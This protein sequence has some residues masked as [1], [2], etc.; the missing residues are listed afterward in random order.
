MAIPHQELL[1]HQAFLERLARDLARD[2]ERAADL[3]QET[4]VRALE[5]GPRSAGALRAWFARVARHLALRG[6][7]RDANRRA[8][9]RAAARPEAEVEPRELEARLELERRVL[10]ALQALREPY[11]SALF[12][13]Y[14]EGLAPAEIARR[15]GAP[16]GTVKTRLKRGLELL[17]ADLA[18]DGDAL[19]GLLAAAPLLAPPPAA[20]A[21]A[22]LGGWLVGTKLVCGAAAGIVLLCGAAL[23]LRAGLADPERADTA[24]S[25]DQAAG[26]EDV[27]RAAPAELAAAV[28]AAVTEERQQAE[29]P[30]APVARPAVEPSAPGAAPAPTAPTA[31]ERLV[32][33][34]RVFHKAG[35]PAPLATVLLGEARTRADASGAFALDLELARTWRREGDY[36]IDPDAALVAV[37]AGYAPCV[38][39]GFGAL[40]EQ[41]ALGGQ[42]IE[43]VLPGESGAISGVVLD[44][45]G[46]PAVGWRVDLQ[47]GT[48]IARGD[49][50][51]LS[52][53]DVA[54]EPEAAFLLQSDGFG[55]AS[56]AVHGG[57]R[58]TDAEGRFRLSGLA[59]DRTYTLRAWNAH[60]LQSVASEPLPAGTEGYV[61]QVPDVPPRALVDGMVVGT[62]G[63]P[64]ADVRCRLTLVEHES[65]GSSWMTTGQE[66]RT[67][68]D[69]RFSFRDVPH[70]ALFV[71]FDGHGGDTQ[72][73]LKPGLEYRDVRVVLERPVAFRFEAL[74]R[75]MA[76]DRLVVEDGEGQVLRMHYE[77]A[78][79]ITGGAEELPVRDGVSPEATVDESARVLLMFLKGRE[80]GREPLA[81]H[82]GQLTVVRR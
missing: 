37:L 34:G 28:P 72:L 51:P 36:P 46:A 69:G 9:E 54:A 14:C 40:A 21:V 44:A 70:S 58:E 39:P 43:L 75:R 66:V 33:R 60:T 68:S 65:G 53:E 50:F 2:P 76:P 3:A 48:I 18:R 27:A 61:L 19:R 12:L 82:P 73:D 35:P 5:R 80:I 64:L 74:D 11:R 55:S 32:L 57:Y 78:P 1:R 22:P 79:G 63:T 17:R 38:V 26:R 15:L 7:E 49:F 29:A 30:E 59:L 31:A 52:A 77:F 67:D 56:E 47:D 25:A 13:R 6:A 4:W 41:R 20:A 45:S 62:D 81:V 10:D 42:P 23:L 24:S 8:R 71:R 16:E